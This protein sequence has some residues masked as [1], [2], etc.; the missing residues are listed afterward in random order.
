MNTFSIA[1]FPV[2][3]SSSRSITNVQQM[4]EKG[5]GLHTSVLVTKGKHTNNN[6]NNGNSN[7]SN[8]RG[9]IT[10]IMLIIMHSVMFTD[11]PPVA[12]RSGQK[13]KRQRSL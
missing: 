3:T 2:N 6:S 13:V 5:I 4:S 1:Q 11:I 12:I 9:L 7:N 8:S 10:T